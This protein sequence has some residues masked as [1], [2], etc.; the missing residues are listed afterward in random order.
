[1]NISY[2]LMIKCLG[3]F[4]FVLKDVTIIMTPHWSFLFIYTPLYAKGFNISYTMHFNDFKIM[5]KSK[6][7]RTQMN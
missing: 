6:E 3:L 5:L 4:A 1:M 7:I 2:T